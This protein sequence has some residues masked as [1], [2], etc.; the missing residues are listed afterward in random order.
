MQLPTPILIALVFACLFA[1]MYLGVKLR[2][3]TMR[4][5]YQSSYQ[6]TASLNR[7]RRSSGCLVP[8]VLIVALLIA[9]WF[10]LHTGAISLT[11]PTSLASLSQ[12]MSASFSSTSCPSGK[13]TCPSTISAAFMDQVL[14]AAGS[15]AQG[16]GATLA[17]LGT[18]Y[19]IDPAYALAFFHHE[20]SYGL[21]GVARVTRSLGN[22][23]CTPGWAACVS[24]FRA[25]ATWKDGAADWFKVIHD[26]YVAHGLDTIQQIIPK[27]APPPVN[28]D[29]AYIQAVLDDMARWQK[30]QV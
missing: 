19:H 9:G 7:P 18:Q 28:D 12:S 20:S 3:A 5:A 30:G 27:Y 2:S 24:G 6:Q 16:L 14:K 8:L 11:L 26:T 25:Y 4:P 13:V 10:V 1:G 22:I 21:A 17:T 15:P 29:A 23:E